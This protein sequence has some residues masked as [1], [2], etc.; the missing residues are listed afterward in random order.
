MIAELWVVHGYHLFC[1]PIQAPYILHILQAT[2]IQPV[3]RLQLL[4]FLMVTN[5]IGNC[6]TSDFFAKM[7][8]CMITNTK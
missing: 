3:S 6:Y 2:H 7:L 1:L 5:F 4:I 8:V